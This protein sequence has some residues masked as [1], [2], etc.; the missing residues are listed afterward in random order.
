MGVGGG[1]DRWGLA[2]EVDGGGRRGVFGGG[3]RWG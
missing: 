3:S 2:V 1:G